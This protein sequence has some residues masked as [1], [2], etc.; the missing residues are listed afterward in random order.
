MTKRGFA[1]SP[2]SL[3]RPPPTTGI[4]FPAESR[5]PPLFAPRPR[6]RGRVRRAPLTQQ[7]TTPG[8]SPLRP[9]GAHRLHPPAA[10]AI[11]PAMQWSAWL[12]H[13]A[14]AALL[15]AISAIGVRLMLRF[16]ILDHPDARKAHLRPTPKGGGVG[17]VAAFMLGMAVLYA[18]AD[19]ARIAEPRFLGVIAAALAIALVALADDAWNFR[20]PLKLGAQCAAAGVAIACGLVL[21]SL[22]LPMLG[23]VPLGVFGVGLTL[24]WIVG[25]TNAVNF[26]DGS[27]GLVGSV[28]LLASLALALISASEGAWFVYAAALFL[29]AGFAGFLPFNLAPARIFMGDVGS[30][31]AGFVLAVLAVAAARFDATQISFLIVPLLLLS[32]LFDA[33]FTLLRRTLAGERVSAPH[34]SHLYQMAVR[35]GASPARVA[36]A[37]AGFT[38]FHA[39]LAA[40]FINLPPAAK[41]LVLLPALAVQL[42]WA[43][44]VLARMRRAGVRFGG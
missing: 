7:T 42:A 23:V 16:P 44:W 17:V 36:A 13:F 37:H 9:Q 24:F 22:A 30:Q 8:R 19:F 20:F 28:V 4:A 39:V 25:C 31:F 29:A 21:D 12:T 38:V 32:L 34:R 15:A 3:Q 33:G 18:E 27:D 43:G 2:V 41:P 35:T 26:M 5:R 1:V 40:A 11:A 10:R 6:R 14:F